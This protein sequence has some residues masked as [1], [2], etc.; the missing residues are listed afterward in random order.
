M[1]T[2]R[3]DLA[4]RRATDAIQA[5]CAEMVVRDVDDLACLLTKLISTTAQAVVKYCGTDAAVQ[6]LEQTAQHISKQ[7]GN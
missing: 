5:Y 6:I 3:S 7:S 2:S 4:E 1:T